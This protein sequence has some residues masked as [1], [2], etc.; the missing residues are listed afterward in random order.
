[1]PS[2]LR[3]PERD[4]ACLEIH[5]D[6]DIATVEAWKSIVLELI[7]TTDVPTIIL[8]LDAV[9]FID[10]KGVGLLV[11]VRNAAI[12]AGRQ[13]RVADVPDHVRK[14]LEL[15]GLRALFINPENR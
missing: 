12:D 9:T 5:G 14:I 15:G 11:A 7:R 6:V 2:P 1:M 3:Q 8:D 13:L 10:A 4:V